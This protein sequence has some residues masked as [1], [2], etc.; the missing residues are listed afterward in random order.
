VSNESDNEVKT[1][2]ELYDT[3]RNNL[4]EHLKEIYGEESYDIRMSLD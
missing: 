1:A 3:N 4:L 2:N